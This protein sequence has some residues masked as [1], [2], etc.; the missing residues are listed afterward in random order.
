MVV[1]GIGPSLSQSSLSNVLADPTLELRDW[2][3]LSGQ[4]N[5]QCYRAK[6]RMFAKI[7]SGLLC[8]SFVGSPIR[9]ISARH[10]GARPKAKAGHPRFKT[11]G[12]A[13]P[14]WVI[15]DHVQC[16]GN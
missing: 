7:F 16:A 14:L 4:G 3:I 6:S 5:P 2:I 8:K 15:R 12:A 9:V 11:S 13:E 10:G 1:R